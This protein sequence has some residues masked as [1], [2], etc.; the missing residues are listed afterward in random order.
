MA[1]ICNMITGEYYGD[2]EPD[3]GVYWKD[4]GAMARQL[5]T[6][7]TRGKELMGHAA[8]LI[9]RRLNEKSNSKAWVIVSPHSSEKRKPHAWEQDHNDAEFWQ[10]GYLLTPNYWEKVRSNFRMRKI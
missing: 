6:P 1:K 2:P 3:A 10:K 9:C 5:S 4:P 8:R 7:G